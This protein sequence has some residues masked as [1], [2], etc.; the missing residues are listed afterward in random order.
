MHHDQPAGR[1]PDRAA[2]P[3]GRGKGPA[4]RPGLPL[5]PG[6]CPVPDCGDP[7]DRT[8]LMC[9]RDWYLVPTQLR[10]RAWATG[11]PGK[12]PPAASTSRQCC[13]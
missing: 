10:D 5:P 2:L 9:R 1:T 6:R 3:T 13:R 12:G 4:G 7:I 11:T 8:R